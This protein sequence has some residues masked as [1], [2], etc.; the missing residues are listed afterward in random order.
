M[1]TTNAHQSASMSYLLCCHLYFAVKR[2]MTELLEFSMLFV[3]DTAI[4][5][6]CVYNFQIENNVICNYRAKL[7]LTNTAA[8][9]V[10]LCTV[11]LFLTFYPS[12]Y[13][14]L[15]PSLFQF[16][17]IPHF[18]FIPLFPSLSLFPSFTFYR[19]LWLS[20]F[21]L[22]SLFHSTNLSLMHS[23][24]PSIN[25]SFFLCYA[26]YLLLFPL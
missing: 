1:A 21:L 23:I 26:V 6:I 17:S 7:T 5:V 4:G 11:N 19:S 8:E 15:Y 12:H 24:A 3:L 16:P 22:G 18:H 14:T 20:L 10:Y 13:F 9:D 2:T 25:P